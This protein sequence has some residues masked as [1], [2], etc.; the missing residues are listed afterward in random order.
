MKITYLKNLNSITELK[1]KYRELSK[2]Y[3]PDL[4]PNIDEEIFKQLNAEHKYL[5]MNPQY[6]KPATYQKTY[7]TATDKRKNLKPEL[8]KYR[9]VIEIK[10]YKL[11]SLWYYYL[12]LLNKYEQNYIKEELEL[13]A[14]LNN[15][16]KG[17]VYY[18]IKEL[19]G[20]DR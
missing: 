7:K 9:K 12:D 10:G 3:H 11:A 2:K 19:E 20:N 16:N 6:I 8:R 5:M 1:S 4:N 15:Y 13:I 18:K 14:T 17:W